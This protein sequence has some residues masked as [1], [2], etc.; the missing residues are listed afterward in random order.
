MS[1]LTEEE[2]DALTDRSSRRFGD[3]SVTNALLVVLIVLLV[4][5]NGTLL[6]LL[7][8][9]MKFNQVASFEPGA[10]QAVQSISP[11]PATQVQSPLSGIPGPAGPAGP[12]GPP[13]PPGPA[14]PPGPPGPPGPAG[15]PSGESPAAQ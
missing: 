15:N 9:Q 1:R 2:R 7:S 3:Y 13:G 8:R 10:P 6:Y 14:G 11:Q 12:P 5:V 4:V